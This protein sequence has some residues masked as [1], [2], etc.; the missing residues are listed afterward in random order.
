MIHLLFPYET[1]RRFMK[2]NIDELRFYSRE[3]IREFGI[4]NERTKAGDLNF[5]QIHLLLECERHGM[6]E[7]LLLAKKLRVHKSYVNRLIKSLCVLGY[8][9]FFEV[10]D[11]KKS[12]PIFLTSSGLMK[13]KEINDE[14]NNQVVSACTYLTSEEQ[15]II[16]KG[17]ALYSE[18]LKK[19]RLLRGI[20][21]RPIEKKDNE[22][23]SVLIK[24]VLS[25]FGANKPGF[26]YTDVETHSM[27]EYYQEQGA[28]YYVA[29]QSN[30][31]LGGIGFA[32]L[33][34]GGVDA[35]ELRKMYL[36][37]EARGLGLG[38]ELLKLALSEAKTMYRLMYLET[39]SRMAQ[40]ISLYRK[41]GFEFLTAPLGDT[42]HYGCDI[43][44]SISLK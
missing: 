23:L 36:T 3:L 32:P 42:G 1:I 25:E 22:A 14:A 19:A 39:L 16:E 34:G 7:Q 44:M 31:L 10:D 27:Y 11:N 37:K 30:Q 6:V 38:C 24:S 20:V 29:E 12:K 26:A 13:V 18:A 2:N 5:A 9:E 15:L 43:W 33:Q 41:T 17:L 35:C 21:I 40:A 28:S 8:I 4:L